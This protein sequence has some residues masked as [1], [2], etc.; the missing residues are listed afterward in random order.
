[1]ASGRKAPIARTASGTPVVWHGVQAIDHPIDQDVLRVWSRTRPDLSAWFRVL[2]G[3]DYLG[4]LRVVVGD[5]LRLRSL[6]H[7]QLLALAFANRVF[8]LDAL[9]ELARLRALPVES[10]IEE[11]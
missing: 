7:V 2:V 8:A 4:A 6:G 3:E 9:R 10:I 11:R 1:M 5:E